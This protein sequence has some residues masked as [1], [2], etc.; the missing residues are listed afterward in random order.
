MV[1]TIIQ[2]TP[3]DWQLYKTIQLEA[4]KE[5]PQAFGSSY[6]TWANATEEKWKERPSNPDSIIL[7][8]KLLQ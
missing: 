2:I 5:D 1:I 6:T 3:S 7:L 8:T 4:L